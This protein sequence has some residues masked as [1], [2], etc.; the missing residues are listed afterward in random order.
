MFLGTGNALCRYHGR[1]GFA[2]FVFFTGS[3]AVAW[4]LSQSIPT[5]IGFM[6][7]VL[8]AACVGSYVYLLARGVM[9]AVQEREIPLPLIVN[10]AERLPL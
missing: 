5:F 2:A 3:S 9:A 6:V 1:Q 4:L 10:R 7:H 8:Y